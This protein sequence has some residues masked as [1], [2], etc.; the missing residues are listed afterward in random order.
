MGSESCPGFAELFRAAHRRDMEEAEQ[1][2]L[3]AL[4][5]SGRNDWVRA[6]V[7]ATR[8][9]MWCE[10]RRG[11]DGVVYTAFGR[12]MQRE[13]DTQSLRSPCR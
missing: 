7:A 9:A 1:A 13:S 12:S 8:R 2:A 11:T 3:E 4:D 6:Q 5:Q 10:D